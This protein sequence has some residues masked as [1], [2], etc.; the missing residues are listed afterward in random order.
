MSAVLM[1]PDASADVFGAA[2]VPLRDA[3]LSIGVSPT[4]TVPLSQPATKEGAVPMSAAIAPVP[5]RYAIWRSL[6]S[7]AD[8]LASYGALVVAAVAV[9]VYVVL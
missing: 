2:L 9:V 3:D 4:E 7:R 8:R 6:E 1:P 5:S